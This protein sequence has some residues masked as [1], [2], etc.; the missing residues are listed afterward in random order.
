MLCRTK[1]TRE[2]VVGNDIYDQPQLYL[3]YDTLVYLPSMNG[4]V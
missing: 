2:K 1:D 3:A 4:V